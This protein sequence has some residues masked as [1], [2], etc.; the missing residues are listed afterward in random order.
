[1][2]QWRKLHSKIVDSLDVNGLPDDFHRLSWVLLPLCL[3]S[4]GRGLDDATWLRSKLFPLRRDVTPEML[5][6][7]MKQL[8]ERGMIVRYTADGRGYFH[9]PNFHKYQG[10]TDREAPSALPPPLKIGSGPGHEL[11]TTYSPLE[12]RRG[13]KR[14]K[15]AGEKQPPARPP[16]VAMRVPAAAGQPNSVTQPGSDETDLPKLLCAAFE[17][18][19]GIA[20]PAS[21]GPKTG[22]Q[23]GALWWRPL[24]QMAALCDGL[25]EPAALMLAT[26]ARM[27]RNGLTIQAPISVV[28]VFT[29]LVGLRRT[30]Q[31][32]PQFKD[33][34]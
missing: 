5:E 34:A 3:D 29:D 15:H 9:L 2:P 4:E 28:A 7:V 25:A 11:V 10:K 24:R 16:A 14:R 12:E 18:A 17:Q 22:R 32:S 21:N 33:Y 19:S 6:A 27:R 23:I 26:V 8:A 13:D 1:M 31:A 20:L 30:E